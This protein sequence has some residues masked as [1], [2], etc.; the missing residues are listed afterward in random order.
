MKTTNALLLTLALALSPL[1]SFAQGISTAV[2]EVRVEVVAGSSVER[3][4]SEQIITLNSEI[5]EVVYGD[6]YLTLPEDV[7]VITS[8]LDLL[9]LE[10]GSDSML[11]SSSVHQT[12]D[13]NG[14]L[15]LQFSA[16]NSSAATSG[17]YSGTQIAEIFY[18]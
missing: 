17:T 10:N 7:Q 3:A 14:G 18:L 2:M 13:E 4:D 12:I 9:T 16:K 11:L 8:A 1:F 6:F 5:D 15:R